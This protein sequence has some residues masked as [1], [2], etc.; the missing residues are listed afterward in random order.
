MNV[1]FVTPAYPPFPGGGERYVRSLA[2]ALVE[3]GHR[4]TAVTSH[5]QTE[6][7]FWQGTPGKQTV[8]E[9]LDGVSVVR[10]P[11]RPFPGGRNGLLVWRKG[12]VLLSML[13]GD[14]TKI[15]TKT[16]RFIPPFSQL[17]KTLTG[18]PDQFDLVHAFNLSWEHAATAGWQ[19]ARHN[20]MPFVVTP[21]IHL[22][23]GNDR[24]VRNSTMDHQ[25]HLMQNADRV[26]VL[27]A[28]E[29]KGLAELGI[30]QPKLDVIGGGLDPL[31][32]LPDVDKLLERLGVQR[33]FVICVGRASYEK[34]TLHA[35]QAVLAL[36]QQGSPISLVQVGQ[37]SPEFNRFLSR[38]DDESRQAIRPLGIL[39]ESDKH[40]LISEAS[41]LLLPS[42]T[43]SFGIV[44]LEAWAH[45]K[46][47]IGARAGG[48][49]GVVDDEQNGL[50]VNFG[51][52]AGLSAAIEK[53]LTNPQ[54]NQQMGQHGR[55]KVT[56]TYAWD[57][58]AARV[59]ENYR[60]ILTVPQ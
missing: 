39:N 37:I 58:V 20:Q 45:G 35:A 47:V 13:P 40:G 17:E 15:L 57:K 5:A 38:L 25:L 34:G 2:L 12:M 51:D 59:V 42:R 48:I 36:R 52:V 1:L 33:P 24:V 8:N 16:A 50:L 41:I 53:L 7:D 3:Q 30:P 10:C 28:V 46:P 22:G 55:Q 18:L 26:L 27:T 31:P 4:V 56:A 44:L 60:A 11:L 14:H 49:P 54:L 29:E 9:R 21:F 43:D 23:T 32:A 6:P 19:F